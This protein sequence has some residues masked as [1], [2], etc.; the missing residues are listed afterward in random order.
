MSVIR[1]ILSLA[2]A[3]YTKVDTEIA[4][5]VTAT[6]SLNPVTATGDADIVVSASN[7]TAGFVTLLTITPAAALTD[8]VIDLD[9]CKAATGVSTV[10]TNNDTLDVYVFGK[11][12]GT[13]ARVLKKGTQKTLTGDVNMVD[14]GERFILGPV[15][16][17][18]VITVGVK[19]SAERADAE[20]PYRVTYVGS[21]APTITAVAAA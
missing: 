15:A 20:I 21:A 8:L 6:G 14:S 11:I 13:N 18:E 3:I 19:L 16:A 17:A 4:T 2:E 10:A 12:D 9:Y 7:Y 1:R 5:L